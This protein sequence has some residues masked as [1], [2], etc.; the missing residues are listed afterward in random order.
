MDKYIEELYKAA[1][2]LK[3]V[4]V[5]GESWLT[6]YASVNSILMVAAFLENNGKKEGEADAINNNAES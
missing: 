3:S 2:A 6:M 4:K 5:D 1:K